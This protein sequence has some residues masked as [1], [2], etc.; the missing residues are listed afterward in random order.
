MSIGLAACLLA[1]GVIGD[2]VGRWRVYLVGLVATALGA[3]S[4]FVA[5]EPVGFIAGRV[6]EGLAGGAVSACGLA[7]LANDYPEAP[8][9]THATALWGT[10]V[11]DDL[12]AGWNGAILVSAMISLVGAGAVALTGRTA[13]TPDSPP[14]KRIVGIARAISD[15]SPAIELTTAPLAAVEHLGQLSAGRRGCATQGA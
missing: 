11:G 14:L 1:A 7:I 12:A 10:S 4:Y 13:E 5:W 15:E 9:R 3:L 6:V 8:R 2:N